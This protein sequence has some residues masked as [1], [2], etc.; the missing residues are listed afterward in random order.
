MLKFVNTWHYLLVN[1]KMHD[2]YIHFCS[3][4]NSKAMNVIKNIVTNRKNTAYIFLKMLSREQDNVLLSIWTFCF[5]SLST[6]TSTGVTS[7]T[8]LRVLIFWPFIILTTILA[9]KD[10]GDWPSTVKWMSEMIITV[11]VIREL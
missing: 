8:T 2:T 1:L 4:Y 5:F 3:V 7:V 9:V 11:N 10:F 6:W